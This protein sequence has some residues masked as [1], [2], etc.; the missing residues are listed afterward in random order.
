MGLPI[1][2]LFGG[3]TSRRSSGE[4][5]IWWRGA[6]AWTKRDN[7]SQFLEIGINSDRMSV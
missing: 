6:F 5:A 2:R 3:H 7:M 1:A 4:Q